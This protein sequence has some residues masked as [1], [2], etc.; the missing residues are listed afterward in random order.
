MIMKISAIGLLLYLS[1]FSAPPDSG[2][3]YFIIN[4]PAWYNPM[5]MEFEDGANVY[6]N[7]DRINLDSGLEKEKRA[8]QWFDR[9]VRIFSLLN[10]T[11]F[12]LA[13]MKEEP[14]YIY[15]V[16]VT[17]PISFYATFKSEDKYFRLVNHY[18]KKLA[19][20]T[21]TR[22]PSHEKPLV[23]FDPSP[24]K[25]FF[26]H[27]ITISPAFYADGL[28]NRNSSASLMSGGPA[29]SVSYETSGIGASL[30]YVYGV[31]SFRQFEN[32]NEF[33]YRNRESP[34][35]HLLIP[36]V[37]YTIMAGAPKYYY[38]EHKIY[39][40]YIGFKT[41]YSQ[42]QYRGEEK[43]DWEDSISV[44]FSN[45]YSKIT[46]GYQYKRTY[47]LLNMDIGY[48]FSYYRVETT[49]NKDPFILPDY[50]FQE[51]YNRNFLMGNIDYGFDIVLFKRIKIFLNGCLGSDI[52]IEVVGV[53]GRVG[54][55]LGL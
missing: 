25:D 2:G 17:F 47:G 34:F 38:D 8:Y 37:Y 43:A 53:S 24:K 33:R 5:H 21:G 19:E 26:G 15:P 18:N 28:F 27:H 36:Q 52:D 7:L 51:D 46:L 14:K 42:A 35:T 40:G 54:C 49:E 55:A 31:S 32:R 44:D 10:L 48:S 29:L 4:K 3:K 12:L 30:T 50:N 9:G 39:A 16:M 22:L 23:Y 6:R 45:T 41:D 13:Y 1:C 11:G 20:M